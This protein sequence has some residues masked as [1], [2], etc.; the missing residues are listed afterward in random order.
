[1][2]QNPRRGTVIAILF[3]SAALS[4]TAT[5][6]HAV[7]AVAPAYE[8]ASR[9]LLDEGKAALDAGD[10]K[11]ALRA[12]ETA[13][14]ADP[15]NVAA[16]VAIGRA[17]EALGQRPQ[18][19]GYYRRALEI[20][21]M[22]RAALAAEALALIAEG[23]IEDAEKDAARL[24]KLCG[25]ENCPEFATVR[26]ALLAEKAKPVAAAPAAGDGTF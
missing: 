17:H 8:K 10:A 26:K 7:I 13:L 3:A 11:K 9:L 1:M 19:L 14:V 6:G 24:E 18:G 16:I 25:A 12:F 21:P 22:N 23:R 5:A 15:A 4:L 2:Y 20:D